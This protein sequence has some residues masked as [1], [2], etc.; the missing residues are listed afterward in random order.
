MPHWI[1]SAISIEV[2]LKIICLHHPFARY[3][4]MLKYVVLDTERYNNKI[5]PILKNDISTVFRKGFF[6]LFSMTFICHPF[7]SYIS[8]RYLT[9]GRDEEK[10]V[11]SILWKTGHLKKII[12]PIDKIDIFRKLS[13]YKI[14]TLPLIFT[15]VN[16][17]HPWILVS[18]YTKLY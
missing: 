8:I 10:N 5:W 17:K 3:F 1:F 14:K 15:K 9:K 7:E 12:Y 11:G 2:P 13:Y 6:F 18:F 16:I 4:K